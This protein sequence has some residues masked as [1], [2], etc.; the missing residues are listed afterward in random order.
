MD[1]GELE[2]AAAWINRANSVVAFTGAGISVESGIPDFRSPGGLWSKFNPD[3]YCDFQT[4]KAK[5]KLF[6][7]MAREMQATIARA[8]P[9]PAHITLVEMEK[10]NLVS[11]VITQNID[12]LHQQ[13]GSTSVFELHGNAATSSC[14]M[15]HEQVPTPEAIG[16]LQG[17]DS[18]VPKCKI[19][20]GVMKM[21]VILF[22]EALT[23]SI[24][25]GAMTAAMTADVMLVVGTSLTV[26]PANEVVSACRR[27]NG[28][29]IIVDPDH[30][31]KP[32]GDL[33]L[34]GQAGVVLPQLLQACFAKRNVSTTS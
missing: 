10:Q 30:S 27:R 34:C 20:D 13:A 9:N 5:P 28:K 4:F 32:Q 7:E 19:C 17:Q 8:Q 18:K 26:S 25:E 6:W 16:Q 11:C 23:N 21:D 3:V 1:L 29:V 31:V 2:R 24:L 14:I 22:G 33:L 12:N 15:C